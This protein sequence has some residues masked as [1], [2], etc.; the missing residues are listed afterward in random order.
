MPSLLPQ[1]AL[2]IGQQLAHSEIRFDLYVN[3]RSRDVTARRIVTQAPKHPST[4]SGNPD[5]WVDSYIDLPAA[6]RAL[7]TPGAWCKLG[8][9]NH[10]DWR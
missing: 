7:E 1:Q 5:A 2:A 9:Y 6:S 10:T 4:R 8:P 3:A